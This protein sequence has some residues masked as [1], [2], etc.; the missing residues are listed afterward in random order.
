MCGTGTHGA[1]QGRSP[2]LTWH[3]IER[4]EEHGG[5]EGKKE[6]DEGNDEKEDG[7]EGKIGENEGEEDKEDGEERK[8]GEDEG[9]EVKEDKK[10]EFKKDSIKLRER[11]EEYETDIAE[12]GKEYDQGEDREEYGE[13]L[14]CMFK[15]ILFENLVSAL[16]TVVCHVSIHMN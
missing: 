6:E 15:Q 9:E 2:N 16:R 13:Y 14:F 1:Q 11:E 8:K 7:E 12:K 4:E 5:E 10:E 3:L